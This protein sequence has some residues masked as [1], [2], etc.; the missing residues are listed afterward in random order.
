MTSARHHHWGRV[1]LA[2]VLVAGSML[3]LVPTAWASSDLDAANRSFARGQYSDAARQYQKIIDAKGYSAPLLFDLGN[4]Y[5]RDGKPAQA[6]LAYERARLLA[7]RDSAIAAN[8]AEARKATGVV[9]TRGVTGHVSHVLTTNE[10]T[11]LASA[12]FW[13]LAA[14]VGASRLSSR[15]RAW[16]V[17]AA[18]A[19]SLLTFVSIGSLVVS[20]GD[21]RAAVVLRAAPMLLSPF[22]GAQSS[23]SIRAGSDVLLGPSHGAYVLAHLPNGRSGWIEQ[24]TV[25]TLVS[26][27]GRLK[28]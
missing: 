27:A 18:V 28:T 22:D 14:S 1:A 10:W 8:L 17:R 19:A 20:R 16:L 6:T 9:E 7:P 26:G 15:R 4:A 11:W 12:A 13:M 25:A 24:S 3:A 21:Q 2:F 23:F 5:L